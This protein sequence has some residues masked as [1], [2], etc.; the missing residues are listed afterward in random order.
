MARMV[1]KQVYIDEEQ[2]RR[3]KDLASRRQVTESSLIRSGIDV[4]LAGHVVPMT[5]EEAWNDL[6]ALWAEIDARH[7]REGRAAGPR[8]WTRDDLYE[9]D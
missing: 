8:D 4:M 3:L 1:R 6:H 7:E 5:P 2:D 9:D